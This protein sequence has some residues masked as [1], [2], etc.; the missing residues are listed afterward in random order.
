MGRV[1]FSLHTRIIRGKGPSFQILTVAGASSIFKMEGVPD[2][3]KL[4]LD[5]KIAISDVPQLRGRKDSEKF[6][7]WV[8]N[9][10]SCGD[11]ESISK[12]YLDAITREGFLERGAGKLVK[13]IGVSTL[14][15]AV[16]AAIGGPFGAAAGAHVG[17]IA[18]SLAQPAV[19]SALGLL[20]SFVL[21]GL[22]KGWNPRH[23]FENQIH[24][25]LRETKA[26]ATESRGKEP[27]VS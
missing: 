27:P 16:G 9:S 22:L 17:A 5:R 21:G 2:F 23:Y 20:D 13:T 24:P 19:D 1:S 7:E 26:N 12:E 15:G 6:R 10:Q 14:F 3:E 4:L 18:S 11:A 8:A 25:L